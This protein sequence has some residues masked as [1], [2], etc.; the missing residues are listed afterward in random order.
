MPFH[1]VHGVFKA[2]KRKCF[3][4]PFPVDHI[5]SELSTTT[6]PSWG[7]LYSMAHSFIELCRPHGHNKAVILERGRDP[8]DK[9]TLQPC[10]NYSQKTAHNALSLCRAWPDAGK[11]KTQTVKLQLTSHINNNLRGLWASLVAQMVKHL[12]AMQKT[13]SSIPGLGRYPGEGNGNPLQYS[14]L[15]NPMDRGPCWLQFMGLHRVGHDWVTSRGLWPLKITYLDASFNAGNWIV[16]DDSCK[17][18]EYS[19]SEVTSKHKNGKQKLLSI[20]SIHWNIPFKSYDRK[21]KSDLFVYHPVLIFRV[22]YQLYLF[23]AGKCIYKHLLN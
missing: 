23:A 20:W 2:R 22:N 10:W 3:A 15:E 7:P 14:C 6:R 13:Q 18:T 1:T 5:L 11:G 16:A 4:I 9:R 12:P 19:S 8:Q 17:S 21:K